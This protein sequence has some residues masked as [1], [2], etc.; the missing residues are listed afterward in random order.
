MP[1]EQGFLGKLFGGV[2]GGLFQK[3]KNSV[4]GVDIGSASVKVV[5][6]RKEKGKAILETYGELA[7]GPYGN[8]EAGRVTNLEG[9]K[10]AQA[11]VDL[12][13]EA[14]V[15][16]NTAGLSIPVRSSLLK[17]I[18]L[19]TTDRRQIARMAPIEARK[20]IPVPISEV[21]IDWWIIPEPQY[22]VD[23][24]PGVVS[25]NQKPTREGVDVLLVAIQNDTI[26][27]YQ[28]VINSA[29]LQ[30]RAFEIETFSTIRSTFGHD[31]LPTVIMDFGASSTRVAIVEHGIVRFSH[32]ISKGSQDITMAISRSTGLPFDKA[33]EIKRKSGMSG[34]GD[35]AQTLQ[36]VAKPILDYIFYEANSTIRTYEQQTRQSIAKVIYVGGGASLPNF[37]T[38]AQSH[39]EVEVEAGNPFSK[40]EAPA[41][42]DPLLKEAGPSFAI[43]LGLAL[44]ELQEIT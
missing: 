19:P 10:I 40:V 43:S 23:E 14:S 38:I 7:L 21:T 9:D 15:T 24:T 3:G 33:E 25:M 22:S 41:F 17:V 13:K 42:L 8:M 20:Y 39:F 31:M 29:G 18:R 36:L 5:Q 1:E 44:R 12:S 34:A 16:A 27:K 30:S 32:V 37:R 2:T 4:L 28:Q 11:I 26:R 35:A 6:L